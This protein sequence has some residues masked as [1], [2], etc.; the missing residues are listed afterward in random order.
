MLE[1]YLTYKNTLPPVEYRSG[2]NPNDPKVLFHLAEIQKI[3]DQI[4]KLIASGGGRI[5]F[6][7][8]ILTDQPEMVDVRGKHVPNW[9]KGTTWDVMNGGYDSESKIA[10][11]GIDGDFEVDDNL[12]DKLALHEYGHE[13]D[14]L[15]GIAIF[16][17][18]IS[19]NSR[20]KEIFRVPPN[21]RRYF[22]NSR[23]FLAESVRLFYQS[24]ITR[25]RLIDSWKN[26]AYFL[27]GIEE[28]VADYEI[29]E[30]KPIF[31]L[32]EKIE[33]FHFPVIHAGKIYR[34]KI[35]KVIRIG[36]S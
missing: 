26:S 31:R 3:P 9:P 16:G 34:D 6:F 29:N 10:F 15:V 32:A 4:H 19:L 18:P 36:Y 13:F 14:H 1:E 8:G 2:V 20:Y 28:W 22:S 21:S 35:N 25:N 17:S 33:R 30:T 5:V 24:K 12:E 23:E 7:N 11:I 27:K